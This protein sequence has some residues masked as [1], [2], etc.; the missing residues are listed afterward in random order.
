MKHILVAAALVAS[1]LV[2]AQE[3]QFRSGTESV[4]VYVT[5]TNREKRLVTDLQ[6]QDF[7][8]YDNGRLQKITTFDSGVL[9]ITVVLMLD[10]SVSMTMV[11]ERVKESAEQFL[12]RL[13]PQDAAKVGAF[14]DKIE[15]LPETGFTSN[16][17]QLIRSLK[18]LDFGNGTRLYD[19]IEQ[20]V[21]LL[22]DT[23][24]RKV[25]LT[26]TDGEDFGSK[27]GRGDVVAQARN[28]DVMVY[29]VGIETVFFNGQRTTRSNPDRVLRTIADE[30]GGGYYRLKEDD[31]VG[32]TFTAIAQELRS[33]YVLGFTPDRMDGQV[34][35]IEVKLKQPGLTARARR[36]YLAGGPKVSGSARSGQH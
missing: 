8:V 13:L 25:I 33:Q 29:S 28:S 17:D 26:L 11:L 18:E 14:N 7:E 23:T 19:A 34:H 6:Q 31:D 15:F 4:P 24:S 20:G 32:A 12:I 5:V 10:T 1:T 16:R 2:A 21:A 3:P 36:T 30:T 27:A 9:P 35:K 22:A